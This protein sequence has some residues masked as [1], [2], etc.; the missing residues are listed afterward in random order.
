MR[1]A[2]TAPHALPPSVPPAVPAPRPFAAPPRPE[3][4][5][6]R[7]A[8]TPFTKYYWPPRRPRVAATV[9]SGPSPRPSTPPVKTRPAPV[10]TERCRGGTSCARRPHGAPRGSPAGRPAPPPRPATLRRPRGA[11]PRHPP[12]SSVA[13]GAAEFRAGTLSCGGRGMAPPG[14]VGAAAA[15]P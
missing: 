9:L 4:P 15:V 6:R 10:T 7:P 14:K 11:E 8:G 12:R 1:S 3:R 5:S 2:F 13:A